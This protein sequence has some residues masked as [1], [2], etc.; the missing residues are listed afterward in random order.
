MYKIYPSAREQVQPSQQG[1]LRRRRLHLIIL[2]TV[3]GSSTILQGG[4]KCRTSHWQVDY[5]KDKHIKR[6][7]ANKQ[8]NIT[9]T[10][11]TYKQATSH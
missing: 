4:S 8:L 5:T 6:L 10:T 1:A 9:Q 11:N 2:Y 3:Y 7:H